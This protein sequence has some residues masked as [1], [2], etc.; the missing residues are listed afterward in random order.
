MFNNARDWVQALAPL[1]YHQE[2]EEFYG[3]GFII[4][5][6]T[7]DRYEEKRAHRIANKEKYYAATKAWKERNREKCLAYW[8]KRRIDANTRTP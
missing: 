8:R 2:P 3:D 1:W 6:S 7:Q 5:P 4:I